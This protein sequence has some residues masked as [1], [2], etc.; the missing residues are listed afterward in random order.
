[1]KIPKQIKIGALTYKIIKKKLD[2]DCGQ[3]RTKE[4]IIY[5]DK[6]M[7]EE[8]EELTFWHEVLHAINPELTDKD[9][10]FLSQAIVQ[11]RRDNKLYQ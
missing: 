1:M 5:L 7:S 8:L 3:Q 10:E 4:Q 2:D 6:D 9:V 11:V